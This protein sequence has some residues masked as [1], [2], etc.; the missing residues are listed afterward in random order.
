MASHLPSV[1]L[2]AILFLAGC[3]GQVDPPP[4]AITC[5]PYCIPTPPISASQTLGRIGQTGT[6]SI[7]KP[8]PA[9]RTATVN[10]TFPHLGQKATGVVT[11]KPSG[12]SASVRQTLP[13][14]S[15]K[16]SGTQSSSGREFG[17]DFG[18]DFQ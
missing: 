17:P 15:Q 2:T 6:A 3:G 5:P 11:V 18:P 14:L 9:N 10:Q 8:K 1:S 16:A 7:T 12:R 13:S 4:I